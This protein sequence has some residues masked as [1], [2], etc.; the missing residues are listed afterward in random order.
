MGV[1]VR[2]AAEVVPFN[3]SDAPDAVVEAAEE[4]T[5]RIGVGE[6]LAMLRAAKNLTLENVFNGTKIKIVHLKALESG[7]TSA[8]PAVPFAAGFVKAYAQFLELDPEVWAKAYRAERAALAAAA[9]PSPPVA[10]PS[11]AATPSPVIAAPAPLLTTFSPA[12][13]GATKEI[14]PPAPF[15]L[16]QRAASSIAVGAVAFCLLWFGASTLTPHQ[17]RTTPPAKAPAVAAPKES[18]KPQLGAAQQKATPTRMQPPSE[19]VLRPAAP[20][21]GATPLPP[22]KA[23]LPAPETEET[24]TARIAKSVTPSRKPKRIAPESMQPS[25]HE[26]SSAPPADEAQTQPAPLSVFA[27]APEPVVTP[28]RLA[29]APSPRYPERCAYSAGDVES[30]EVVVDI[31][32]DGRPANAHVGKTSNVCFNGA[33]VETAK[34]MRFSPRTVDGRESTEFAKTVTVR[35]AR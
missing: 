29:S 35:F 18:A 3:P 24:T 17:D 26:T 33:A 15:A 7:D 20:L 30:V 11:P 28:A 22:E 13:M 19:P 31:M 12:T 6:Q 21:L 25:L 9:E 2:G 34:R 4:K 32:P 5:P 10:A 14:A 27:P 16:S 1:P 8:L 23:T